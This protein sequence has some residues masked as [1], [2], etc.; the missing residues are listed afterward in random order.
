MGF[1]INNICLLRIALMLFFLILA[2]VN[3][4]QSCPD[5]IGPLRF[6]IIYLSVPTSIQLQIIK[7]VHCHLT[8]FQLNWSLV[9]GLNL[10]CKV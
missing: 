1:T 7:E 2:I 6:L 8:K 5:L 9:K 4:N 3:K 10:A